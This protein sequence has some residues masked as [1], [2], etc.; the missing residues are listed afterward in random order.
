MSLSVVISLQS[1]SAKPKDK[2]KPNHVCKNAEYWQMHRLLKLE[3][4]LSIIF[5]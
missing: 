5:F 4:K 3:K 2:I 1:K